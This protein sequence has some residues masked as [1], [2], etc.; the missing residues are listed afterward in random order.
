VPAGV[1]EGL[2]LWLAQTGWDHL[3]TAASAP[4]PANMRRSHVSHCV[5][6]ALASVAHEE[7]QGVWG[8]T[9]PQAVMGTLCELAEVVASGGDA[10]EEGG[11]LDKPA[12]PEASTV[13]VELE[14]LEGGRPS[15]C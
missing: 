12:L 3:L 8:D 1:L 10:T 14:K 5:V 13:D 4:L 7:G 11:G 9:P 6:W 15:L 2:S